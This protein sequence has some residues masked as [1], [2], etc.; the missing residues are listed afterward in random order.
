VRAGVRQ[1]LAFQEHSRPSSAPAGGC[2]PS[3]NGVARP[4]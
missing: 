3:Y 2:V 4:T 1:V